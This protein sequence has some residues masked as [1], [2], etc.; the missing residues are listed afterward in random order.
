MQHRDAGA[1]HWGSVDIH[2]MQH[3]FPTNPG[4][5][6]GRSRTLFRQIWGSVHIHPGETL[7]WVTHTCRTRFC[8]SSTL[9]RR[10][11]GSVLA[12]LGPFPD[13]SKAL[14]RQIQSCFWENLGLFLGK[15]KALLTRAQNAR[16]KSSSTKNARPKRIFQKI[17]FDEHALFLGK[18]RALFT[19]IFWTRIEALLTMEWLWLVG[20]IEL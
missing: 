18:S 6:L 12:D 4:L 10:I 14:F 7:L 19:R 11:H 5:C 17:F 3:S 20:S 8:K 2:L 16:Q 15:S 9:F 1:L 13:K